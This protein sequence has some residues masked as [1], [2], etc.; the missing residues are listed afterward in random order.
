M[1]QFDWPFAKKVETV[2]TTQNRKIYG[3]M[4][5]LPLWPTYVEETGR[6]LDKTYGIKGEMLLGTPLRNTLGT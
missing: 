1:S 6:T 2:E 3:Q 5:C 4:E